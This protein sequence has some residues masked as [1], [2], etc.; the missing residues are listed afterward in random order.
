MFK[1]IVLATVI[2]CG[3]PFLNPNFRYGFKVGYNRQMDITNADPKNTIK[4]WK[5]KNV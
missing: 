4:F 2:I 5:F 1:K 3:A